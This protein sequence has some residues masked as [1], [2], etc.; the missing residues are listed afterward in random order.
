MLAIT[1][2]MLGV[3]VGAWGVSYWR[4]ACVYHKYSIPRRLP[5]GD[6]VVAREGFFTDS[7]TI[8]FERSL[9]TVRWFRLNIKWFDPSAGPVQVPPSEWGS[10]FFEVE[11]APVGVWSPNYYF[12]VKHWRFLGFERF[13]PIGRNGPEEN[14]SIPMWF[15]AGL[16]ATTATWLHWPAWRRSRRVAAGRC[17]KCKYERAG[18]GTDTAC[19]ECGE[20]PTKQRS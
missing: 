14:W 11:P 8:V 4:G 17:V 10:E 1:L 13:G 20:R 12:G 6:G 7:W 5:N 9:L 19:P 16:L 3:V 18:L 15:I 2:V